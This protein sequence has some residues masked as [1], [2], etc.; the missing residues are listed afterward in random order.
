MP[1]PRISFLTNIFSFI[2]LR[3][4]GVF[5]SPPSCPRLSILVAGTS[6]HLQ[7]HETGPV[8]WHNR[9][10]CCLR[11]Q[12]SEWVPSGD[13]GSLLL[14][15][16]LAP[17]TC[18]SSGKWVQWP[19]PHT[20]VEDLEGAPGCWLCTCLPLGTVIL[21]EWISSWNILSLPFESPSS[22]SS[23][24]R[25]QGNLAFRSLLGDHSVFSDMRN[26]ISNNF[27]RQLNYINFLIF[28][29]F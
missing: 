25:E 10:R 14:T 21:W 1:G 13:M 7:N 18:E 19:S 29:M 8:L 23:S 6:S 24:S 12:Y 9:L 2:Y 26:W 17:C 27:K 16:L 5:T 22:S 20:H 28:Y 11:H 3:E 15:W 4:E